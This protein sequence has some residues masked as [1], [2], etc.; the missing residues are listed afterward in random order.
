[1]EEDPFYFS[2][3][4]WVLFA[5]RVCLIV[6][7]AVW[8]V[9]VG[10]FAHM[11]WPNYHGVPWPRRLARILRDDLHVLIP[12]LSWPVLLPIYLVDQHLEA[13]RRPKRYS[14]TFEEVY[15]TEP[16]CPAAAAITA[17]SR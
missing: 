17:S 5:M 2:G 7:V 6:D 14:V 13:K 9:L 10:L 4:E 11:Q 1:M 3:V 8:L 16:P 15:Y 12:L